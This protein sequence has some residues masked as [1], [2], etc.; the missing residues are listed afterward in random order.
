[1]DT[2]AVLDI[3]LD[4]LLVAAKLAAPILITALVVGFGISLLQSITQIQEVT[5]SFVPK[6]LAVGIALL[7][8]GHWMISEIVTFTT[9][10]FER[11][12]QLLG[13]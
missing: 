12:P 1:M 10:L 5:L 8:A 13:G 6:A 4:A 9:D 3:G 11:I 2:N 7:V